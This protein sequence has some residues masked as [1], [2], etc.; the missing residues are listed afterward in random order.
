MCFSSGFS[1]PN[2]NRSTNS[3]IQ[4]SKA[5]SSWSREPWMK[6]IM[7]N[8]SSRSKGLSPYSFKL[9][10]QVPG[11]PWLAL[12]WLSQGWGY[13]VTALD[14]F[15]LVL[16][17]KYAELLQ[18]RFSD[19]FHEVC[20]W[21]LSLVIVLV[22][23]LLRSCL[24]TI[25]CQCQLLLAKNTRKLSTSPGLPR[26]RILRKSLCSRFIQVLMIPEFHVFYPSHRCILFP[27]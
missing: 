15:L 24:R 6:S 20:V 2:G 8:W 19:D 3:G 10:T 14:G 9:W 23:K 27:A 13:S 25:T 26:R 1:L 16:F 11:I 18:R 17:E 4:W 22:T 21:L 7:P 5:P 12:F